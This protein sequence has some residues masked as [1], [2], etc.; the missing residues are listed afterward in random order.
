[1]LN[2]QQLTQLNA[3]RN[4]CRT[5]GWRGFIHITGVEA[6]VDN[7]AHEI[8]QYLQLAQVVYANQALQKIQN[9][10]GT[11]CDALVI[12]A[13]QGLNPNILGMVCACLRAGGL[14]ILLSPAN[15][16]WPRY[17]DPDYQRMLSSDEQ[18]PSIVGR[19]LLRLV[20]SI[21]Q[22]A[23]RVTI[24][25]E[26]VFI[27]VLEK[28]D[29]VWQL[30]V[31]E[32]QRAISAI[33]KVVN[34][35]ARRPLVLSADRGRGKSAAI[36]IA[37]AQ[38][39]QQKTMN[40]AVSAVSSAS[41]TQLFFHLA[42]KLGQAVGALHYQFAESQISFVPM[43]ELLQ[44]KS[45]YSLVVIDEAAAIPVSLLKRCVAQFNR[46]VFSTT[47]NGYEGNGR[48]FELR[49]LPYLQQTFNQVKKQSLSTPL[50]W[51]KDDPLE[52]WLNQLLLLQNSQSDV[53]QALDKPVCYEIR[54]EQLLADEAL[55]ARVFSLLVLAHYQ[56]SPDDLRLLLDHPDLRIFVMQ[57]QNTIVA[58][59]LLMQEGHFAEHQLA[60]IGKGRRCRGHLLPQA[61]IGDGFDVKGVRFWRVL[62]I[63]VH[64]ELQRH[65]LGK[66]LL[67]FIE[68]TVDGDMIGAS[69][70]L[71][72]NVLA[73]WQAAQYQLSRVGSHKES[74][75]GQYAAVVLK[76]LNTCATSLL[77]QIKKQF[78]EKLA[79]QLLTQYNDIDTET[80]LMLA[81]GL[82]FT[83]TEFDIHQV[84]AYAKSYR[85]YEQV[86]ASLHNWLLA[87][88]TGHIEVN[89][90]DSL[91]VEK[92][93]LNRHWQRVAERYK[94]SGRHAIE[95][96][97]RERI[98]QRIAKSLG[99]SLIG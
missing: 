77:D 24:S 64:P 60:H 70:S 32:Q 30:D 49:F 35:H 21:E 41:V 44:Q 2:L 48:G 71:E 88:L 55:L 36:G 10:L 62:R 40:I 81:Q 22:Q 76:A 25:A 99:S 12:N 45:S 86:S 84:E 72:Q 59:A 19:F 79:Y 93:L 3:Y 16:E 52:H 56:T 42:Q 51:A 87:E 89:D 69:F 92:V 34:G 43:D 1:M 7:T 63:V 74:S 68:S 78:S 26:H 11:E 75:T 29:T 90:A 66:Q 97:L 54:V 50:R 67:S 4:V 27:P 6:E 5:K 61:L 14:F 47:L 82:Y 28:S 38:L 57:D 23:W 83:V 80:A 13:Y 15:D 17:P 8:I 31:S 95:K 85:S 39:M 9:L 98:E 91:L 37:C 96:A 20:C 65:G 58:A 33:D 53:H 94:L 18:L 73:F 46:M